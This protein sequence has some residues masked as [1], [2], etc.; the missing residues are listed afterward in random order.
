MPPYHSSHG[1]GTSPQPDPTPTGAEQL[2]VRQTPPLFQTPLNQPTPED[3]LSK[4]A[5]RPKIPNKSEQVEEIYR[6]KQ[7]LNELQSDHDHVR[8]AFER[9]ALDMDEAEQKLAAQ[10]KELEDKEAELVT[11]RRVVVSLTAQ[12]DQEK[13][14]QASDGQEKSTRSQ[15]PQRVG[16][17]LAAVGQGVV[18]EHGGVSHLNAEVVQLT[19]VIAA[20]DEELKGREAR[21]LEV[22]RCLTSQ[23]QAQSVQL[24]EQTKL[25]ERAEAA[26]ALAVQQQ[27]TANELEMDELRRLCKFYQEN[28]Q[29]LSKQIK[30]VK[31]EGARD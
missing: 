17:L 16:S 4:K 21:A 27:Q 9:M 29:R 22:E 13:R 1:F 11:L 23:L 6:L 20:K 19:N 25:R 8:D 5:S 14:N 31:T 12:L 15:L 7:L 28:S 30:L 26:A 2:A 24:E 18:G 3:E 10:T